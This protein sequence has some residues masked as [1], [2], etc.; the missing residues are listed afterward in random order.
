MNDL[1]Y[2]QTDS[3]IEYARNPRKND[4]AVGRVAAAIR[5][6]G[7]RVP[8]VAKSDGTIVDGHLRLKAAK[9]LGMA[10][11]PILLADD[12]TEAQIKAFRISVNKMAELAEW[13]NELLKLEFDD[14]AELGFDL[15]LTGFDLSEIA[16]LSPEQITEGLTDEDVV[17]EAPAEP[18]TK[19]GDVWLL[20]R[21]RVMCGDSTS[22]DAVDKLMAGNSA[23]LLLT[24]PPYGI[25]ADT[26]Q[27]KAENG[28]RQYGNS[29]W[30]K[31]TP[32]AGWWSIGQQLSKFQIV[33]GGNYF[34]ELLPPSQG[35]LVWDKGQRDFS[36]ADGEL[37]WTSFDRAL[38][39]K[40]ISRAAALADGK[41]HPTQKSV[42]LMTWCLERADE[43]GKSR[44]AV[45][46]D[47]FGG[48][49]TTLIAA[50]QLGRKCYGMEISPHYCDVIIKRWQDFTGLDAILE[51]TGEKYSEV[52]NG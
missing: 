26:H 13:D 36:L 49:G 24:D 18:I 42:E 6:F 16:A 33:W 12:M 34:T 9:K 40:T 2:W 32:D 3:L 4:Q 43:H 37:A 45:V 27:G 15:E 5:E 11:V 20:G 31:S 21:H 25:G 41:V 46:L 51:A 8:I 23:D 38:R 14:L 28:W 35:W 29:G 52:G 39:I 44:L 19:E 22:I 48:S 47:L 50:E 7:F 17:P 1:Q 10:E 30:D